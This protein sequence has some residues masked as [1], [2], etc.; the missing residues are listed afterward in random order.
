MN[1]VTATS[2]GMG[3]G[4]RR[5]NILRRVVGYG[6]LPA[7]SVVATGRIIRDAN[8]AVLS[9][10]GRDAVVKV[11]PA[12]ACAALVDVIAARGMRVGSRN[13]GGTYRFDVAGSKANRV[14][15]VLT[16]GK[17]ARPNISSVARILRLLTAKCQPDVYVIFPAGRNPAAC[18]S[19]SASRQRVNIGQLGGRVPPVPGRVD[20]LIPLPI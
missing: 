10:A 13:I 14:N 11:G 6:P 2:G 17:S 4:G 15:V 20:L 1:V 19:R 8:R 3:S 9:N 16:A 5:T 12:A 18:I 7:V